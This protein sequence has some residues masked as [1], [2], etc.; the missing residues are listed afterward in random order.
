MSGEQRAHQLEL[1]QQQKEAK[2]MQNCA[3]CSL[4]C[5]N[6]SELLPLH[7][8]GFQARIHRYSTDTDTRQ[9][10]SRNS[11]SYL[12]FNLTSQAVEQGRTREKE[13]SVRTRR[14]NVN[15]KVSDE[16]SSNSR[17]TCP[18]D[19]RREIWLLRSIENGNAASYLLLRKRE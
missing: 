13:E 3:S 12:P 2:H 8:L 7:K 11:F 17:D 16:S 5:L 19:K 10:D 14:K 4:H 15:T 9:T 6:L 18:F 1:N